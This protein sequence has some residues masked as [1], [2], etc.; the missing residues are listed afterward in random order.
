MGIN[1]IIACR[2]NTDRVQMFHFLFI[3]T[4]FFDTLF[5]QIFVAWVIKSW[6]ICISQNT[7]WYV[8]AHFFH[9]SSQDRTIYLW[10]VH[11]LGSYSFWTYLF[12]FLT[13]KRL[14]FCQDYFFFFF[15]IFW[16]YF[17]NFNLHIAFFFGQTCTLLDFGTS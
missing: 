15:S 5:I 1:F 10:Y 6:Y 14:Y 12:F 9:L 7:L 4:F 16:C 11:T 13:K 8:I 2:Q 3:Q 17:K